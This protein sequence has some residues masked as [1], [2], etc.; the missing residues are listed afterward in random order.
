MLQYLNAILLHVMDH[1]DQIMVQYN[2]DKWMQYPKL[3]IRK[4]ELFSSQVDNLYQWHDG[5]KKP[6]IDKKIIT[7]YLNNFN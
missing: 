3:N 6:C 4:I 7:T 2:L 1:N 5:N